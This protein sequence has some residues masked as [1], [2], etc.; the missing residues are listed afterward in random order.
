[1]LN[2]LAT[3][4][5]YRNIKLRRSI[6]EASPDGFFKD[7]V[8]WIH[9]HAEHVAIEGMLDWDLAAQFLTKCRRLKT[10]T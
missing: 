8:R 7:A 9:S 10:L 3:P 1:M 4:F 2:E 6:L 5:I